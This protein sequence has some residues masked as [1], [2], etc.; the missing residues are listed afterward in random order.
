M[1]IVSAIRVCI[2]AFSMAKFTTSIAVWIRTIQISA[3]LCAHTNLH[4]SSQRPDRMVR[5]SGTMFGG[6][7]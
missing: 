3:K 7:S 1:L 2:G 6:W 5:W 4:R